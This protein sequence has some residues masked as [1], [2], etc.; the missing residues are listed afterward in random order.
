MF[1]CWEQGNIASETLHCPV[2]YWLNQTPEPATFFLFKSHSNQIS[3]T[4]APVPIHC[5]YFTNDYCSLALYETLGSIHYLL[6]VAHTTVLNL[7]E[8]WVLYNN[9]CFSNRYFLR[10]GGHCYTLDSSPGP[11]NW[12]LSGVSFRLGASKGMLCWKIILEMEPKC[13]I[14][15]S[16]G[17]RYC[18]LSKKWCR[19]QNRRHWT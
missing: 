16:S 13:C 11:S 15:R 4:S 12:N 17:V 6:F 19:L 8:S 5:R 10:Y 7:Q 1:Y 18:L 3:K 14:L 9:N 2:C